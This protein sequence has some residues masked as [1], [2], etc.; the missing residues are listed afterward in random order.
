MGFRRMLV[1]GA[2]LSSA[3]VGCGQA[4]DHAVDTSAGIGPSPSSVVVP[5]P[6]PGVALGTTDLSQPANQPPL[7]PLQ[8]RDAGDVRLRLYTSSFSAGEQCT[9]NSTQCV[10]PW[11]QQTGMLVAEVSNDA[12][13]AVQ[14]GSVI[15]VAPASQLSLLDASTVGT[16]EHSPVTLVMVRVARDVTKVRF[17]TS[18]GADSTAPVSGLAVL[19][20]P[21]EAKVATITVLDGDGHVRGSITL[22]HANTMESP[23]CAPQPLPLPKPGKQPADPA[24]AEKAVRAAYTKAYTAVPGDDSYSSLDAVQDG[25]LLHAALDQLRHNFPEAAA[26]STVDTGELVFTDPQTAVLKFTLHYTG[27]APYGTHNGT[28]VLVNGK[29]LVSRDSYCAVLAFGGATC[30]GQ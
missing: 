18:A 30:P 2:V 12:M 3:A 17:T 21:G 8:R 1:L 15:G 9:P 24:R 6:P 29:W 25:D 5:N 11:C 19:A 16:A 13:A 27:G 26:S 22:P 14:T 4:I 28:A 20:V 10:P 7:T 23:E